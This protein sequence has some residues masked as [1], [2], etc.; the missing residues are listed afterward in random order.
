MRTPCADMT[1]VL[2]ASMAPV[3][4]HISAIH[5]RVREAQGTLAQARQS[6]AE[7]HTSHAGELARLT[8]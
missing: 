3:E 5:T 2:A 7:I 1:N 6:I 8:P 4:K